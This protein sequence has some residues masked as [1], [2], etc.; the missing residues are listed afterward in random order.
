MA[1]REIVALR[2]YAPPWLW[3]ATGVPANC[4]SPQKGLAHTDVQA[5]R[6]R[7]ETAGVANVS[8]Q[9][10]RNDPEIR[11]SGHHT[12]VA[13]RP[14]GISSAETAEQNANK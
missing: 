3:P 11:H 6:K 14:G 7:P 8:E 2:L 4:P 9:P 5:V 1:R 10:C 12:S 13:S